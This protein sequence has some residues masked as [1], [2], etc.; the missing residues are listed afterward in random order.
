M[1]GS[2]VYGSDRKAATLQKKFNG[3]TGLLDETIREPFCSTFIA[4]FLFHSSQQTFNLMSTADNTTQGPQSCANAD[5]SFHGHPRYGN[6]CSMCY[7]AK[8]SAGELITPVKEMKEE[9]PKE[10]EKYCCEE[11]AVKEG[12]EED[13]KNSEPVQKNRKRCFECRKKVGLL[14]I[15]CRCGY[16]YCGNHRYPDSHRCSFDF[17]EFDRSKLMKANQKVVAD[18]VEMF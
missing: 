4:E 15:E 8:G 5:C 6:F 16:V 3:T 14:G 18:K 10:E 12:E 1:I 2:N 13:E 9:Q 11:S 17:K 7:K